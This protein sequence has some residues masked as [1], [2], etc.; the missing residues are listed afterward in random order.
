M[1]KPVVISPPR[2]PSAEAIRRAVASSTALE[3]GQSVA[4]LEQKL[5]HGKF[6]F[7]H[8]KLAR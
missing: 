2:K 3:T 7:P 4:E 6:R 5:Q 8:V 1:N